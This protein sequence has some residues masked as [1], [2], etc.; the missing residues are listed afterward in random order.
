MEHSEYRDRTTGDWLRLA[1]DYLLEPHVVRLR[2]AGPRFQRISISAL[3]QVV[4]RAITALADLADGGGRKPLDRWSR[5]LA[6]WLNRKGIPTPEAAAALDILGELLGERLKNFDVPTE[7]E[8]TEIESGVSTWLPELRRV[9]LQAIPEGRS[10]RQHQFHRWTTELLGLSTLGSVSKSVLHAARA[11]TESRSAALALYGRSPQEPLLEVLSSDA[12]GEADL[13]AILSKRAKRQWQGDGQSDNILEAPALLIGDVASDPALSIGQANLSTPLMRRGRIVGDL[14]LTNKRGGRR[15]TAEDYHWAGLVADHAASALVQARIRDRDRRRLDEHRI[16]VDLSRTAALTSNTQELVR[17]MIEHI[18]RVVPFSVAAVFFASQLRHELYVA[19]ARSIEP[20]LLARLRARMTNAVGRIGGPALSPSSV[21][22]TLMELP[23]AAPRPRLE[24][25]ADSSYLEL[26]ILASA[27][28][29]FVGVMAVCHER[30]NAFRDS[31]RRFLES[32]AVQSGHSVVRLRTAKSNERKRLES[33]VDRLDDGVLLLDDRRRITVA[34]ETGKHR[35]RLLGAEGVGQ[36]LERLGPWKLDD[37]LAYARQS[38]PYWAEVLVDDPA[39]GGRRSIE[40]VPQI[41]GDPERP[42]AT[43]LVLRDITPR[44]AVEERETNAKRLA[45]AMLDTAPA[46]VAL[47]DDSFRVVQ[48]N[49]YVE[50]FSGNS[51]QRLRGVDW[52]ERCIA[53]PDRE[54]FRQAVSRILVGDRLRGLT[55]TLSCIGGGGKEFAWWGA[56]LPDRLGEGRIL[57]V[58]HDMTPLREAQE[59]AMQS[60]RL[61]A[62]GQVTTGLGHESRNAL[63]RSQAALDRLR[64]RISDRPDLIEFIDQLE[65]A[66]QHLLYLYDEVRDYAAPVRLL[67]ANVRPFDIVAEVWRDLEVVHGRRRTELL[68]TGSVDAEVFADAHALKQ[69]FRNIIENSLAACLDPVVIEVEHSM[70]NDGGDV[71]LVTS[72]RDNGPGFSPESRMKLFDPFFSTKVKGT[73][74]GMPI[75]RRMVEAH[76]GVITV[77][78]SGRPGAELIVEIPKGRG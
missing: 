57:L 31:H 20:D 36:T 14:V 24:A 12:A 2:A 38:P 69:V 59:R 45:A 32:V 8:R 60:E 64:L 76:G 34:N 19:S 77:G 68:Q 71:W 62:I 52:F 70:V 67:K 29:D 74:L 61:A 50:E 18:A 1:R 6:G 9:L 73:G 66:Q 58:G 75:A 15:F 65:N 4:N 72:L 21:A 10:R 39:A 5:P 37:L 53:E 33:I 51:P 42:R 78:A 35:L 40:I 23:A 47:L 26:P 7:I 3:Q 25:V 46:L 16:L 30:E 44:R 48:V 11:L 41:V 49:A 43:V 13:R 28:Q 55:A 56:L 27:S 22:T 17:T 63:Q 54:V